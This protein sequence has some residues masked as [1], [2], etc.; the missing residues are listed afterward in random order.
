M[1][2]HLLKG[3]NDNLNKSRNRIHESLIKGYVY[4]LPLEFIFNS[5]QHTCLHHPVIS[6]K[7][8]IGF[9]KLVLL[10][11]NSIFFYFCVETPQMKHY[12]AL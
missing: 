9:F 7:G 1:A 6:S 10:S 11:T 2:E 3:K 8:I 4:L 5:L 12:A